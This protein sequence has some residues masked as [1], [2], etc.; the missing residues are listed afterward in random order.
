MWPLKP[1]RQRSQRDPRLLT[2]VLLARLGSV[3]GTRAIYNLNGCFNYLYVGWWFRQRGFTDGVLVG[4]KLDIF[5][6]IAREVGDRAVLYLEF[7]VASGASMRCWSRLLRHPEARLH[8]FDSFQGLPHDWSLE[9]HERGYFS[10][11]G[12][13][14]D[15]DDARAEL[16]PGWFAETLP[17]YRW[18]DHD[19][20]VAVLDADLYDS[21]AT[22]LTFL[23]DHLRPGSYLYFDQFHHRCDELRAFSEFIDENPRELR[24]VATTPE[25]TCVAFQI[26]G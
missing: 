11:G 3:L 25:H 15:I 8:G 6:V 26:V 16:F 19:V 22:A 17:R 14:P 10:T 9:G 5:D 7:G 12:A 4:S 21:T 2:K 18:R 23:R 20:L 13:M 24:L 1:T